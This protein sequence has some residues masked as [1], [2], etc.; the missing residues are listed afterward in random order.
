MKVNVF[1][2]I[3]PQVAS[4]WVAEQVI[5]G[6][7]QK[8]CEVRT[9]ALDH[10]EMQPD[11]IVQ[12]T[13]GEPW[14]KALKV[15]VRPIVRLT[16]ELVEDAVVV[17]LWESDALPKAT[18]ACLNTALAILVPSGWL[19]GVFKVSG[20][21]VPVHAVQYGV[22]DRFKPMEKGFPK[23]TVFLTAGRT[24]HG[25]FRKGV[26][27]VISAFLHAFPNEK[28]VVL[29]VKTHEDCPL[30][31]IVSSRIQVIASWFSED[32]MCQW[33]R[34]GLVYVSGSAGEGWG[35]HQHEAMACGKAVIGAKF[36]SVTEFFDPPKNGF[37]V[38]H[39]LVES[40]LGAGRW[41][42][43]DFESLVERMREVYEN[44]V[45][46]FV[47]GLMAARSVEPLTLE[48]MRK[49]HAKEIKAYA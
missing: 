20:V 48:A 14:P 30:P 43:I 32:V 38:K 40:E 2:D 6:L 39:K 26:D 4:G 9:I 3:V 36:G 24:A 45:N 34:Q 27:L 8:G 28:D 7:V 31:E 12:A 49:S 29:Q 1:A 47:T 17:T 11:P 5:I 18:V 44:P 22:S 37:E 33:Y 21:K 19:R 42:K 46:A 16:P 41:A 35:L 10:S 23:R 13:L 15:V 25:R